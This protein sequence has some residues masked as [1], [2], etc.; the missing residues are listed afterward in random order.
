MITALCQRMLQDLQLAGLSERTQEA[1]LRA[2]RQLAEHFHTPPDRLSE[3]QLRDY[4]LHLKND[5]R[6]ASA[7][8]GIAYSG[9][10]FFYS[11]P[12]PRDWPTLRRLCVRREKKLPDVLSVAEVRQLI[13]AVRTPHNR[14]FFWT[15]YSLGLRLGEGLHLQVRDI[16]SARMMVHVHRGKGA[17]DRYVPLPSH[18]LTSLRAYWITH[19]HPV[20]LFPATGRYHGQATLADRPMERSSVQGALRRVVRDLKLRKTISMHTLRH[21]YATHLLEAGVNLRL[22]QQY[23]GHSSLQTTMVYL[24]LTTVSH[25]QARERINALMEL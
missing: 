3:Q 24:H 13:A 6:F 23:L 8:L 2:V 7:S 9:I 21:S 14:T 18:T 5:R 10:K 20:W 19:R 11:H 15:V 17:K 12:T 4:F 16:D 1:Y 22:I 25:E